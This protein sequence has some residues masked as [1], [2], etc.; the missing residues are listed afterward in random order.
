MSPT[1]PVLQ[2]LAVLPAAITAGYLGSSSP[3]DNRVQ[4]A[5]GPPSGSQGTSGSTLW[6]GT[7][8]KS[9][10]LHSAQWN[11]DRLDQAL[12]PLNGSFRYAFIIKPRL[13]L[14]MVQ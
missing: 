12:L 3:D 11:L 8:L 13:A 4:A 9:Q 10:Q 2:L 1:P 5:N 6:M 14:Y 7:G